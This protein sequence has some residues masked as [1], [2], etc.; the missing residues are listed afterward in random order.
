MHGESIRG[1]EPREALVE[2]DL[3]AIGGED[4]LAV[5][6]PHHDVRGNTFHEQSSE[7]GHARQTGKGRWTLTGKVDSDPT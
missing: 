1:G 2:E 3:I 4:R 7:P 6:A 5:V